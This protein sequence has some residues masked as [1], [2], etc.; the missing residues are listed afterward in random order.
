MEDSNEKTPSDTV[1][2]SRNRCNCFTGNCSDNSDDE[3]DCFGDSSSKFISSSEAM[4]ILKVLVII[5]AFDQFLIYIERSLVPC[6]SVSERNLL[7]DTARIVDKNK[8]CKRKDD[9][10]RNIVI[11]G[12][13]SLGYNAF[14]YISSWEKSPFA[15]G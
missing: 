10:C 7:A 13:I 11:E 15:D 12:L 4:E 2:C 5:I 14:I 9:F 1:R 3:F 6:S 8:I